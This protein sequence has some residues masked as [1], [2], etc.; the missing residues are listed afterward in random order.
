MP[1]T[2]SYATRPPFSEHFGQL[3]HFT[4]LSINKGLRSQSEAWYD[5]I[6]LKISVLWIAIS[7][8]KCRVSDYPISTVPRAYENK[9]YPQRST[10]SGALLF[11]I[12]VMQINDKI[13]LVV[14]FIWHTKA[15]ILPFKCLE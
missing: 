15:I 4:I 2:P 11:L 3:S 9:N 1:Q 13:L 7:S 8:Y 5:R 6:V 10:L 14:P 12:Y